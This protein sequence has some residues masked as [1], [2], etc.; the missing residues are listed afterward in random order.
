MGSAYPSSP[1]Q[2]H[3]WDLAV[4]A[5]LIALV[6]AVGRDHLGPQALA[7]LR[8]RDTRVDGAALGP[9]LHGCVRIR[10]QVVKPRGVLG[11]AALGGYDDDV[12]AVLHV[13]QGSG[14][15]DAALGPDVVEQQHRRQARE[16]V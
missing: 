6:V 7:L 14:A 9:D 12:V 4:R 15:L 16:P 8:R 2:D 1:L 3:E 5:L 13:Q 10:T 11:K